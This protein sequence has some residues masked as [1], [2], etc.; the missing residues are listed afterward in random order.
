MNTNNRRLLLFSL[1]TILSL[2]LILSACSPGVTPTPQR[3]VETVVVTQIIEGTPVE[4]V[5]TPT[6]NPEEPAPG[7]RVI[8]PA[9]GMEACQPF[10]EGI[11]IEAQAS[12]SGGGGLASLISAGESLAA[13]QAP[14]SDF[15]AP[16]AAPVQQ[17]ETIYRVGVFE[18]ITTLNFWAANGPDNTVWNSYMLPSRLTM[19]GL[20]EV[21]FTLVPSLAATTTP[22]P[23]VEE[24]EFW[25]TEIPIREGVQWSDGTPLTASDVAFSAN[26]PLQLGLI[27]GNW[28]QWVDGNF[29]DH[30]EAVDDTTVKYYYHTRPGMARHEF[31]VLQGP[32]LAE[33]YWAPIVEEA[34]A[35]IAALPDGASDEE[36]AAAQAEAHDLLFAHAPDG[37]PTAGAYLLERWETGAFLDTV[38]NEGY[39]LNG[40]QIEQFSNGAYRDS[41]G[42][43]VGEP[44][45]EPTLRLQVGPNASAVVY[46]VYG[47]QDA[48]ILAL[49]NGEVDFVLNSLGLQ[50]G[51][52]AQVQNDPNLSVL[53]NRANSYRYLSFNNRRR[54]MN[55]C[56]FRQAVAVLVDK[57]FV[58][59]TILQDA[60]FPFYT[61]VAEGNAAWYFDDV[62]KLGRGLTRDQRLQAAMAI[63]EQ[64]G[65]T[66]EGD[67]KPTYD[68]DNDA[69]VPGG[70]LVMPDGT[71]VP[72]LDMWA[73]NAG[74]DPL[75]STFAIWIETWLNE[76][77]I[78]VKAELAGFNTL[79][80]RIFT[81]QDFDMYILGWSLGIFPSG[82]RDFFSE[83][84]AAQDGNN[85]GGYI[86]EEFEQL[87]QELL[88]CPDLATCKP[89]S[90]EIQR[91]LAIDTP[92]VVLFDTGI[93]EAYR[94]ASIEFPFTEQL[95]GLQ[96]THQ[97][98][99][100]Q[101]EVNIK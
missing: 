86:S 22:D 57:E 53:D 50:R 34:L 24:G 35:P 25:V 74:Y 31:G 13:G 52:A 46:T 85:A 82:L 56:A 79:I 69:V 7:E 36:L 92:Y 9:E 26:A 45:G 61:Y 80:P 76:V 49:K 66:W 42:V 96:Y 8:I 83:E 2:T 70:R 98:G 63:L 71:P 62:P 73:P 64:A 89:I 54:P 43:E 75:R 88:L 28:S 44:E 18:D 78:P 59:S 37:E 67:Q 1:G 84:Q 10:P 95:S 91:Y 55:D 68:A 48:A 23:L 27:S 38:A 97:G 39:F 93:L 32:I 58:T 6:P 99:V 20:S 30:V 101:A 100:L 65:Y 14:A 17:G 60:A 29:L 19:Y 47:S 81:E 51:L 90:D 72:E 5:V 33:H 11:P 3:V 41:E 12:D 94:S 16:L 21:Y 77:G 15:G 87:S 4:V 40:L